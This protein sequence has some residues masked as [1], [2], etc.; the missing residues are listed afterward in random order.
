[1]DEAVSQRSGEHT[2]SSLPLDS[3]PGNN[4]LVLAPV[5]DGAAD[6]ACG[7][8][9]THE[10]DEGG[11][12]LLVSVVDSP[13][14]RLNMIRRHVGSPL[15]N[16]AVVGVGDD[17][18]SAAATDST[19]EGGPGQ[20]GPAPGT[21]RTASVSDASDL[22]GLG[23]RISEALAA[24][25]TEASTTVCFHSVTGLLQ[26]TG[27]RRGFQF[28]H[29]LTKRVEAVDGIAHYHMDP[30]AHDRQTLATIRCLFDTVIE[31]EDGEW[32]RR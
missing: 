18:R 6:E 19:A 20:T 23:I 17:W 31:Y 1:M 32:H 2:H 29:V 28:L 21:V 4:I 16:I 30:S 14:E 7:E 15:S 11:N 26:F 13:G 27:L 22:T 24:W 5:M 10:D 12:V 3:D 25:Q 8:L 9:L